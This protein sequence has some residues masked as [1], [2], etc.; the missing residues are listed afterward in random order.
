MNAAFRVIL[1]F[2]LLGH[3]SSGEAASPESDKPQV[4]TIELFV[5]NDSTL[6]T[7]AVKSLQEAERQ[8]QGLKVVVRD[9][10]KDAK[11]LEQF[12]KL[13]KQSASENAGLPAFWVCGQ[14]K[15]G[16]QDTSRIAAEV[17][18]LYS[19]HAYVRTG[20][21]RCQDA[22][23]F[24]GRLQKEWPAVPIVYHDLSSDRNAR[25]EMNELAR[26]H[27]R[28]V[29]GLPCILVIN[30]LVIGYQSDSTTGAKI[31]TI[32]RQAAAQPTSPPSRSPKADA[33]STSARSPPS[34]RSQLQVFSWIDFP[35]L[36]R[37]AS[38]AEPPRANAAARTVAA[39]PAPP[40]FDEA[41]PLPIPPEATPDLD[42]HVPA[43]IPESAQSAPPEGIEIPILGYLRVADL[44]LAL[45]TF[46]IG[47]V[48]GFNPCAMWVLVFLLSVLVNLKDR[49]RIALVAGTFV[50]VSGL[51]YF[52]F[53]SAWLNVF[54][55][56]GF[57]R[58]LEISLGLL[59]L[60]VGA[61]NVKD[62]FAFKKG[63]SFSIPESAK[64]GIY[65]RVRQIV[66]ARY[67]SVALSAAAVL[68]IGVNIIEL[69]CTAGLP[70][71]YTQILSAQQLPAWA[72]YAYL[73][74]YILA[75]MLDDSILLLITITT[76][77]KSR[78][79]E[80]EGRWLKLLS[81]LVIFG[82]G[83][84]MLFQPNWLH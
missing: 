61:V 52:A 81:G 71:V 10:L 29:T 72:N 38:A 49:R 31:E 58:P 3:V 4:I 66:S 33:K 46:I 78:L 42:S 9:V 83:L 13:A 12:W 37:T 75:Y 21:P 43:P 80:R 70:A 40:R 17:A 5:R 32:L 24:L 65:A 11:A 26:R 74:I 19:I 20:C 63:L 6:S 62:F 7:D 57:T 82:L 30:E 23:S 54:L 69:A 76:L 73:G 55:L 36:T 79:Q 28:V 1:F 77:S 2:T 67:M 39:P 48:D 22:K 64:P 68:A 45:F 53:M 44:G 41:P 59:A 35:F 27:A 60:F 84:T 56:I 15:M 14:F 34:A 50:L 16:V 25:V 47:L 51:A 18:E 8:N